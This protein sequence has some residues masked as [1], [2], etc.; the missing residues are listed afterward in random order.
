MRIYNGTQQRWVGEVRAAWSFWTRL[1]GLLGT[2]AGKTG[3]WL[4]PCK[5]VHTFGIKYPL[6]LIFLDK[7][8]KV[9]KIVLSVKPCHPSVGCA[10]ADSILEFFT[11]QWDVSSAAAGDQLKS[12]L[13]AA[14]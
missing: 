4:K 6:D 1:K 14:A 13:G 3:L 10:G 5:V 2:P 12:D 8:L 9:V 11:G 7:D